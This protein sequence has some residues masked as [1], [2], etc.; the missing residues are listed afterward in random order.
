LAFLARVGGREIGLI[1]ALCVASGLILGFG[2]LAEEVL[3]GDT[4]RFDQHILA[5]FNAGGDPIGPA[6]LEEVGRDVTALG[7]FVFLGLLSAAI[8]G[9]L[10]LIKKPA[11]AVL[12]VVSA[13]GGTLLSTLLKMG[14]NRPRPDI[15][16][17]A[18]VFTASFPSGHATVSAVVFLTLGALLSRGGARRRVKSYF[19]GLAVFLTV[20]VGLSRIYLG[21]H[22]PSDVLAGWCVGAAWASL[23]WAGAVWLRIGED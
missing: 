23:C 18:R 9:Y 12:V 20:M 6:W 22:Y 5:I 14:F 7:S 21:V 4:E 17:T 8:V 15:E 11:L 16:S 13:L 10:L 2:M 1:A 19:V 3:E